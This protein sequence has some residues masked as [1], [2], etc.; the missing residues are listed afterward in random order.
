M[1]HRTINASRSKVFFI[2][3]LVATY[4]LGVWGFIRQ[5]HSW[6]N[7][8]YTCLQ[9]IVLNVGFHAKET[10]VWQLQISRFLLPLF[11]AMT[12]VLVFFKL[13]RKI[14]MYA[15]IYVSREKNIFV[16]S[17]K[18][19][20]AIVSTLPLSASIVIFLIKNMPHLQ[21][22]G[23]RRDVLMLD[24]EKIPDHHEILFARE[25]HNIYLCTGDTDTN[26]AAAERLASALVAGSARPDRSLPGI[27]IE[28]GDKPTSSFIPC[29][30]SFL[31][32]GKRQGN[33][34]WLNT[35]S[36]AARS[37]FM[38]HP[39][40]S[41]PSTTLEHPV[42][43]GI[44]GFGPFAQEL[45]LHSIRQGVYAQGVPPHITIFS[46]DTEAFQRF[47]GRYPILE[48]SGEENLLSGMLPLATF[49]HV[50]FPVASACPITPLEAVEA[51]HGPMQ[52][53]YVAEED[54]YCCLDASVKMLQAVYLCSGK[55]A[56]VACI[57]GNI[58]PSSEELELLFE[59]RKIPRFMLHVFHRQQDLFER[60][61]AYP[62]YHADTMGIMIYAAY[63]CVANGGESDLDALFA[64]PFDQACQ[65][66]QQEWFQLNEEFRRSSRY[67]ADHLFVKLREL[68]FCLKRCE[69]S[70]EDAQKAFSALKQAID[71]QIVLL[72]QLEHRR[73]CIERLLDG[74]LPASKS[75][76]PLYI[77]KT[78][79]PFDRLEAHERDKDEAIIRA[80]PFILRR[81]CKATGLR[82]HISN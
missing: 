27:I 81:Y 33:I 28:T 80:F 20:Y 11:T 40:V 54:D 78:L 60:G 73:F 21:A 43:I 2:F 76:K 6:L 58:F 1:Y 26:I 41:Q 36:Q 29:R 32:Y 42:H 52:A 25:A 12:I 24:I 69:Q 48:L 77:N 75:V 62:G 7:A 19:V 4:F 67:A 3:L 31:E 14:I 56:L 34:V 18:T 47:L 37:V 35:C 63:S 13:T 17:S 15:K 9:L 10:L 45:V 55:A 8:F 23:F 82:L 5:G 22:Q 74:W 30:Q 39:P 49:S 66:A 51:Q 70:V 64:I 61:E 68:G 38:R 59:A 46:S 79:I 65:T 50:S 71:E 16:G 44:V 53:V 57:S 72:M